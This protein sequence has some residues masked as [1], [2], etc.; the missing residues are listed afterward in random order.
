MTQNEVFQKA[1]GII[2]DNLGR[3]ADSITME[4]DFKNDLGADLVDIEQLVTDFEDKFGLPHI[5]EE[6]AMNIKTV[7]DAVIY[8][9]NELEN[10]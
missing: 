3:S 4:M 1:R 7:G 8:V 5:D 6:D 2:A 9:T 10:Q